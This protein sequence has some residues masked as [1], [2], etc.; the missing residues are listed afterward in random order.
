MTIAIPVF[1]APT[2]TFGAGNHRGALSGAACLATLTSTFGAGNHSG[3]LSDAGCLVA[4]HLRR[5]PLGRGTSF[6]ASAP[7]PGPSDSEGGLLGDH[8]RLHDARVV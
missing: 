1:V 3:A 7:D 4:L 6:D 8:P 2:S 5:R